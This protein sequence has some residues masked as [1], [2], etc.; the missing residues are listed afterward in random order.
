MC[1][2]S[3]SCGSLGWRTLIGADYRYYRT[4]S[5]PREGRET[6]RNKAARINKN[7]A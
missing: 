4:G 6:R 7:N 3:I 5:T 2:S 1:P